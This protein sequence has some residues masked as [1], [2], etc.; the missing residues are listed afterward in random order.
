MSAPSGADAARRAKVEAGRVRMLE[1]AMS[2]YMFS[3]EPCAAP[4]A[5]IIEDDR[6]VGLVLRRTKIEDGRVVPTDET[7]ERRGA[8][9][10][11]SI[12]SIPEPIEGL[13]MKGELIAYSDWD[14]GRID[15]FPTLFAA[16]NVV[17]GKGNIVASRKHAKHVSEEAVE[18]YLGLSDEDA[19]I[20][21]GLER[22]GDKAAGVAAGVASHLDTLPPA[23]PDEI[24]KTLER[25]RARQEEVGCPDDYRDWIAGAGA[26]C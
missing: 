4:E 6:V 16:G 12:G 22:P 23:D 8:A 1:K 26:P 19:A 10:I 15:G 20:H 2:K 3:V 14:F 11:S 9:V 24:E 21:A 25:V 18:Q 17:T 13:P 5:L 7:F